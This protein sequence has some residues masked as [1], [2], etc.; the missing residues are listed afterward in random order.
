VSA[1]DLP[2]STAKD[3]ER[4]EKINIFADRFRSH[5]VVSY[6]DYSKVDWCPS[7]I[8]PQRE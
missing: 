1:F 7:L 4:G 6:W 8:D 3:F 5:S 2:G